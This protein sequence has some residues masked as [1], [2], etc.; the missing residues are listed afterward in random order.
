MTGP[1]AAT[2]GWS[3]PP[4]TST[5]RTS[6]RMFTRRSVRDPPPLARWPGASEALANL[7][8]ALPSA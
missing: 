8:G 2:V 4:R 6:A 5:T 3:G 1:R 7:M